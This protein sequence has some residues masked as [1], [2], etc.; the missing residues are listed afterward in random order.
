MKYPADD[1]HQPT[2]DEATT[3]TT[4]QRRAVELQQELVA[5]EERVAQL[6][7]E[8][9]YYLRDLIPQY[10]A[11]TGQK[12]GEVDGRPWKIE[13]GLSVSQPKDLRPA[14]HEWLDDHGFEN[15]VKRTLE[16]PLGKVEPGVVVELTELLRKEGYENVTSQTKVEAQTLKRWVRE[17]YKAQLEVP[18]DLIQI[19]RTYKTKI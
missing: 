1:L 18:E 14:L 7:K 5:A 2:H 9:H 19:H 15:L 10:V 17:R 8:I 3:L 12:P 11:E 6:K 4:Y 16:V 13:K